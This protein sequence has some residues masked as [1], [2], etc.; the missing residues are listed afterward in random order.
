ME[1]DFITNI[2]YHQILEDYLNGNLISLA[3]LSPEFV[4]VAVQLA[5][6]QMKCS[7][8]SD[9]F[10]M[11]KLVPLVI[12]QKKDDGYWR[13]KVM[14]NYRQLKDQPEVIYR[15]QVLKILKEL[16]LF[17]STTFSVKVKI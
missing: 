10:V 12:Y 13:D 3:E 1:S 11:Q 8:S 17:G 6:L 7:S 14:E 2:L 9:H 16:T 4:E 15:R 5:A